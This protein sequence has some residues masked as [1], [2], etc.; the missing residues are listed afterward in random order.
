[1]R[2]VD[3]VERA[4]TLI[5]KTLDESQRTAV[6]CSFGKDSMVVLHMAH[7]IDPDVPV[8]AVLADTEFPGTY[9][10]KD[11]I[12]EEW[13]LDYTEHR[14][15]QPDGVR[16]D[17]S[18]CCGEP[19]IEAT[20][21]ALEGY[22]AWISGVRATEGIVRSDFDAVEEDHGLTKV[23][24]ILEFEEIDVWRYLALYGVPV[25]PV[26]RRGFRSLGCK[27]CSTPEED[28]GESERAGRWRGTSKA[29]GECGIHT[30]SMRV[31]QAAQR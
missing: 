16:E 6:G 14:F 13:D 10:F 11:R 20:R 23:N 1:M 31:E 29:R 21:E 12:V 2:F 4:R 8:F 9:E 17:L 22:D 19:K 25:N 27:L 26:Y 5:E 15:A 30:K 18:L 7:Q 24:P 28:E 3:K